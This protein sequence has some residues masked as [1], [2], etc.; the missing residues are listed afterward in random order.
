MQQ[1]AANGKLGKACWQ[2]AWAN[3]GRQRQWVVV[4][5]PSQ[6]CPATMC[7][8][9]SSP[10]IHHHPPARGTWEG[11]GKQGGREGTSCRP[12]HVCLGHKAQGTQGTRQLHGKRAQWEGHKVGHV[13]WEWGRVGVMG[14]QVGWKG[15]VVRRLGRVVVKEGKC[16]TGQVGSPNTG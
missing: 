1:K 9:G 14:G 16:K 3:T 15:W 11:N 13:P 4:P 7:L 6:V 5:L 2:A 12:R 10:S 8:S